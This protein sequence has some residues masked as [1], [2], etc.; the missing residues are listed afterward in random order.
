M[1]TNKELKELLFKL[2]KEGKDF[3]FN[4]I[5]NGMMIQKKSLSLDI[6]G[7]SKHNEYNLAI[8]K[9]ISEIIEKNA[10][11]PEDALDAIKGLITNTK[12]ALKSEV[13]LESKN[14]N[15]IRNF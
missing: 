10:D 9:K 11:S 3:D 8:D 4:G 7:H 13:L 12:A 5:D 1:E 6:N 14:V 15:D 2:H